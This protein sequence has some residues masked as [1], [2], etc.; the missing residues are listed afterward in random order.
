M[1]FSTGTQPA[2]NT[3]DCDT[4]QPVETL[5]YTTQQL[6]EQLHVRP[7]TLATWR[8]QGKGPRPIRVGK[9]LIYPSWVVRQWMMDQPDTAYQ[10][11]NRLAV[12]PKRPVSP[13]THVGNGAQIASGEEL[14]APLTVYACHAC[15]KTVD[16]ANDAACTAQGWVQ[17][18]DS[19]LCTA[20][21][22]TQ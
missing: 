4:L 22:Y 12:P 11:G 5:G 7:T 18:A 21:S 10:R 1:S 14:H 17:R 3:P 16:A 19:W 8:T 20:C 15:S 6:A 2:T 9:R 13:A